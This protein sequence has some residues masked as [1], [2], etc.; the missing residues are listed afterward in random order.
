MMNIAP[1]YSAFHKG[2]PTSRVVPR[3]GPPPHGAHS[4]IRTG[5]S[6]LSEQYCNNCPTQS[7]DSTVHHLTQPMSGCMKCP[8]LQAAYTERT[9]FD[10]QSIAFYDQL[11]KGYQTNLLG[12]RLTDNTGYPLTTPES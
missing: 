3:E 5:P 9:S 11:R 1:Q 8:S 6:A 10:K 2:Y 12:L 7:D 4:A